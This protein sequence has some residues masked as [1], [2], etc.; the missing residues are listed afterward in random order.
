M[1]IFVKIVLF[2]CCWFLFCFF[3]KIQFLLFW[4]PLDH[5]LGNYVFDSMLL[6]FL[7]HLQWNVPLLMQAWKM[8]PALAAGNT[9]VL[10]PA[11]QTPLTALHIAN[12][13]K[14]AGFPPGVV[15]VVPGYGPTAGD[16]VAKHKGVDKIAFTGSTQVHICWC[17]S[18]YKTSLTIEIFQKITN[19][20]VKVDFKMYLT[21]RRTCKTEFYQ[22]RKTI[23]FMA[24]TNVTNRC[25]AS[26]GEKL[27]LFEN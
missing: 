9:L 8:A 10:K 18:I 11:E 7:L 16:A 5:S 27:I 3:Q 17:S 14:E 21:R 13:I 22:K 24:R 26:V 1:C 23:Y 2:C 4:L 6:F 15:N 20:N 19:F 25:Q 12:L